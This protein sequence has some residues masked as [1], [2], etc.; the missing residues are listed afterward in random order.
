MKEIKHTAAFLLSFVFLFILSADISAV[1][2]D[3]PISTDVLNAVLDDYR[4]ALKNGDSYL[5]L[6]KYDLYNDQNDVLYNG[7]NQ[8]FALNVNDIGS[9]SLGRYSESYI[10]FDIELSGSCI[11]GVKFGYDEKYIDDSGNC[12]IQALEKDKKL[13]SE[14]FGK[15]LSAAKRN[16]SDLEKA[17]ALYDYLLTIT[18]YPQSVGAHG[19]EAYPSVSY[20]AYGLLRDGYSTCMAYAKL[21]A[22]LLNESGVPA[23]TVGSDTINHEWLMVCIDG[24]WYHCDPTWDDYTSEY[25]FTALFEPNDDNYDIGAVS[26][27][28][29][30]KSDD[31]FIDLEH[32]DWEVSFTVNP[33]FMTD[34]PVSGPSGKFD[35]KFFSYNND[36]YLCFSPMNYINGSWYFADLESCSVVRTTMDGE[37]EYLYL[38]DNDSP[39]Y[40]FGY[41]N[42]LYVSTEHSIYRMDTVSGKFEKIF[43]TPISPEKET[44]DNKFI[45][46]TEMC[47]I[48]DE[49]KLTTAEFSRGGDDE[50]DDFYRDAVFDT[51]T[52][53]MS[54]V[55]TMPAVTDSEKPLPVQ[56][57]SEP[58]IKSVSTEPAEDKT[59]YV[60]QSDNKLR[61]E[62][63]RSASYTFI[64]IGA[65]I[66]I[67]TAGGVTAALIIHK[68]R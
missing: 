46:F 25:G 10:S 65:V 42:D 33:D 7:L 1:G 59:T 26:H 14:R 2:R 22:I 31:E 52:Y 36:N 16:M 64:I 20:K 50:S 6:A 29:F 61:A 45:H 47:I 54:V 4:A 43:E 32:P 67:I 9:F 60:T 56:R 13:V 49:M 68:K 19:T 63:I 24:E 18:D 40:S 12:D 58:E 51:Q 17:L 37:P 11:S 27:E 48:Y 23:V 8:Y 41:E 57:S 30:L 62:E 21:Y 3:L 34:T 53:P 38:P 66:L 39:L 44:E 55:R 35:D 5:S 15:A 28:Y